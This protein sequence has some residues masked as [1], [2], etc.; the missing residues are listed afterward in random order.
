MT[1]KQPDHGRHDDDRAKIRDEDARSD[2]ELD[3]ELDRELEDS[4]PA[5]D[6][7]SL[8]QDQK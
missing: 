4:F 7:P 5:S 1:A 6:P 3:E 2:K 8:T